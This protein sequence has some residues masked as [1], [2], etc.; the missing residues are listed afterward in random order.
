MC[1]PTLAKGAK[2]RVAPVDDNGALLLEEF[3]KL[4]NAKTKLVAFTQVSNALGTI[5]PAKAIIEMA[6]R[7]GACWSMVRSQSRT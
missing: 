5:T 3:G 7:V 1:S 2:L 4:L 6:H